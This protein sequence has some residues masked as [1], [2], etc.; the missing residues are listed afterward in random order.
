[1]NV[2]AILRG[3]GPEGSGSLVIDDHASLEAGALESHVARIA[4]GLLARGVGVGDVVTWQLPNTI[5]ALAIQRACWRIGAV[6]APIHARA[7]R[8]EVAAMVGQLGPAADL[9][10]ADTADVPIGPPTPVAVVDQDGRAA[11]LFT[12]GSSGTPKGVVH[13]RRAL[14]YKA[15][16]MVDVHGLTSRDVVLMPAP[17]AHISGMLNGVLVPGAAGMTTVLM[18]KWDPERALDLIEE[19]RVTFMVGPTTF[20]VAMM[21]ADGF[22]P[23]RVESMRVISS[24]GAGVTPAFVGRATQAFGAHVKRSYGS[25][26]APTITTTTSRDPYERSRDTDG[27]AVGKAELRVD[28]HGELQVRGPELFVGYLDPAPTASA[29][30]ADGWFR[31]GD[32]ATIDAEGWLTV[33][34]RLDNVIIRGGENISAAEVEGVL[35]EHPLIRHAVAVGVPDDLLGERVCAFVVS[36][37]PF[38]VDACRA[39]FEQ[40]GVA[41][42]KTPERVVVLD[43]LPLLAAGKPDR[44]AL[45]NMA[46]T[47]RDG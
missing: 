11:V 23:S 38:D 14:A 33:E 43:A 40:R 35:E 18:A 13:S 19:H 12:A 39:W 24:G 31:T 46:L 28:E 5:D 3:S 26:E 44:E 15:S 22:A 30:T 45:R 10:G 7:G 27:R 29:M 2:D 37:A 21:D 1:M 8:A 36:D 34:G 42:F 9:T 4:G 20:F 32:R 16:L 25:T 47:R 17:L 6:A 41:R